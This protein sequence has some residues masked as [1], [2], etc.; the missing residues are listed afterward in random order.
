M[1]NYDNGVEFWFELESA[2][3]GQLFDARQLSDGRPYPD[4]GQYPDAG[5]AGEPGTEMRA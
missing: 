3:G 2:D 4:G 1:E 5:Q